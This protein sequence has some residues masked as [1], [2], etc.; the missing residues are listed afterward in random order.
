MNI[1]LL[2]FGVVGR[3]VYDMLADRDDIRA[4][5]VLCRRDLGELTAKTTYDIQD[6]L[7]DPAVDTVVEVMGGLHP[8]YEYVAAAL[9]AGKNVVSSNKYL[10]CRYYDELNAL[11]RE[12]D[13]GAAVHGGG[14]R[15]H[16]VAHEPRKGRARQP[17]LPRLG[18]P[19]RH[20]QLHHGRDAPQRCG[21]CRRARA[22]A[23]ARLCRGRPLGRHR[24]VGHPAQADPVCKRRLRRVAA[25]GG[26][27]GVRHPQRAQG[28]HRALSGARL[29][30]QADRCR[31]TAR[32]QH[33]RL[34]RADAARQRRARG[35]R[36]RELQPHQH[37]R[38]PYGRAELLRSGRGALP[39][40]LQRRA[41]SGGHHA[42][43]AR[44]LHRF[45]RSG[46]AGQCRRAAPLLCAHARRAA[47]A[48]RP[49]RGRLGRA[50]SSR[51]RSP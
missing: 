37:G 31:R 19:Q 17:H 13:A 12:H 33:Q 16:P 14:R 6:I 51:S 38:R 34:R 9:R 43:R 49:R 47:G 29:H 48:G 42:R 5:W 24:R 4:A 15:R 40:C 28:G 2:G 45:L 32:R 22:G 39:D 11:A 27:A 21:L 46:R 23:G 35:R 10:M 26:R 50:P 8:A 3:G 30:V 44:L 20:D 7:S 1:G 36:A 18:H 41:G 25:R